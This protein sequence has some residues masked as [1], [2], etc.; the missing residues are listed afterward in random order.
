MITKRDWSVRARIPKAAIIALTGAWAIFGLSDPGRA[1]DATNTYCIGNE[2]F[3]CWGLP[4]QQSAQQRWFCDYASRD[5]YLG[6]QLCHFI[7]FGRYAFYKVTRTRAP[8]SM[9]RC[10]VQ[11]GVM[12]C[13]HTR[14]P[15]MTC[16]QSER[17]LGCWA[18]QL[19]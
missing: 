13:S 5:E 11:F 16:S 18:G 1:A 6:Q 7:L 2:C 19:K 8:I 3:Q 4:C 14:T 17:R 15:D 12:A 10:G 9:G